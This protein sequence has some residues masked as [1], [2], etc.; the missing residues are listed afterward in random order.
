MTVESL[1]S[2]GVRVLRARGEVDAVAVPGLLPQVG[3]LVGGARAL[4]LDLTAVTFFDSSG[5]RLVDRIGR[6]AGR[7][8]ASYLVVA[9]PG[10]A[11]RRVLEIVG[12][13]GALVRDDLDGAL[14]DVAR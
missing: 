1:E 13:A 14:A 10:S 12:M 4:V 2:T 9:P 8:G 3:T 5:V 11:A 7:T 6:E